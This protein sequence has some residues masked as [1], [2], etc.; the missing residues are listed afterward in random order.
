MPNFVST[1]YFWFSFLFILGK[2][3]GVI[4][5]AS[6]VHDASRQP[7]SIL[8]AVPASGYTLEVSKDM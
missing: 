3:A 5:T 7:L 2:V 1:I 4:F 8:R 6:L